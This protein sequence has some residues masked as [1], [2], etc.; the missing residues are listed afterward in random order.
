MIIFRKNFQEIIEKKF[1]YIDK[2]L[3][4]K[5]ILKNSPLQ[6]KAEFELLMQ[7]G[8]HATTY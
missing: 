2:T 6:F 5:S 8:L 7:G 4:I 1:D 3:L